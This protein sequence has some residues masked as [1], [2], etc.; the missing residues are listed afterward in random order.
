MVRVLNWGMQTEAGF[1]G[2]SQGHSRT[3][4]ARHARLLALRHD[5]R[6]AVDRV[7]FRILAHGQPD[8]LR[9]LAP[10][11]V[12]GPFGVALGRSIH[13]HHIDPDAAIGREREDDRA[14][15]PSL[16][17]FDSLGDA[18]PTVHG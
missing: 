11:Q 1:L 2:L 17:G 9:P 14:V 4:E 6:A 18:A 10:F 12:V 15:A 3:G 5:G 16:A 8:A 7:Q 13:Q